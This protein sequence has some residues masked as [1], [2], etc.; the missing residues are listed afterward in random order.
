MLTQQHGKRRPQP[1]RRRIQGGR[2][3]GRDARLGQGGPGRETALVGLALDLVCLVVVACGVGVD[4]LDEPLDA[5]PR[6]AH[7][8]ASPDLAVARP[9]QPGAVVVA[10]THEASPCRLLGRRVLAGHA[11]RIRRQVGDISLP[12]LLEAVA[13]GVVVGRPNELAQRVGVGLQRRLGHLPE[14]RG[15]RHLAAREPHRQQRVLPEEL[16]ELGPQLL[17][18]RIGGGWGNGRVGSMMRRGRGRGR[19]AGTAGRVGGAG[20]RGRENEDDQGDKTSP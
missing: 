14:I 11:V 15:V 6:G 12:Q 20:D 4:L 3:L 17:R 8:V 2:G 18:R 19:R 9:G 10:V 5:R 16:L 13:L 1:L 7:G